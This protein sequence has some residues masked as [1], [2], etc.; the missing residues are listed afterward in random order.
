MKLNMKKV[1][2]AL[3]RTI[4]NAKK[5]FGFHQT[6]YTIIISQI[7]LDISI[8]R[9]STTNTHS[10]FRYNK[11]GYRFRPTTLVRAAPARF[12]FAV[13]QR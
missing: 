13:S 6:I 7:L 8:T 4:I 9:A 12:R 3:L 11:H 1:F 2:L 5:K 10:L